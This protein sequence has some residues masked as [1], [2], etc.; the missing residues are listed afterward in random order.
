MMNA[1]DEAAK[2]SCLDWSNEFKSNVVHL[3]H[4]MA[5]FLVRRSLGKSNMATMQ[6][7]ISSTPCMNVLK[8]PDRDS[9]ALWAPQRLRLAMMRPLSVSPPVPSTTPPPSTSFKTHLRYLFT[10]PPHHATPPVV[11]VPFAQGKERNAAADPKDVD[12]NLIRD[13]DYHGTPTPDPNIHQQ[14]QAVIVQVDT[15]EHGRG[16]SCCCC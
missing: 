1:I 6:N 9:T 13:E 4:T 15:G 7:Q 3:L 12:D 14:H 2:A 16:L 11:D 5:V 8:L 10:R